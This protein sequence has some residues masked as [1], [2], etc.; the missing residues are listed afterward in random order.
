RLLSFSFL[1]AFRQSVIIVAFC[2]SSHF[3]QLVYRSRG[4]L[5]GA[6]RVHPLAGAG[7]LAGDR[8]VHFARIRYR[9]RDIGN[10]LL[11]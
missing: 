6:A 7:A 11:A 4:L 10:V 3:P 5:M 9:A 1:F 2:P 8:V